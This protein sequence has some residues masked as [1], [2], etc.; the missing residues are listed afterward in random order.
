MDQFVTTFG[1]SFRCLIDDRRFDFGDSHAAREE[2]YR[3]AV[4]HAADLAFTIDLIQH[5]EQRHR[6]PQQYREAWEHFGNDQHIAVTMGKHGPVYHCRTDKKTFP[7][8]AAVREHI[9]G[10]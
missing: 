7:S 9:R 4:A 6:T 1:R 5:G 10:D 8:L 3:A 2:Q